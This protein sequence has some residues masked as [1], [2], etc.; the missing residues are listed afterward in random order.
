[1]FGVVWY[2]ANKH[3]NQNRHFSIKKN[4]A[5]TELCNCKNNFNKDEFVVIGSDCKHFQHP[6]CIMKKQ[7]PVCVCGYYYSADELKLIKL[8]TDQES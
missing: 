4:K 6:R 2:C 3:G 7:V 5:T 1:L 8:A